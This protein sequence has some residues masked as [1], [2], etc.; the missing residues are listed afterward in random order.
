MSATPRTVER[1]IAKAEPLDVGQA[2]RAYRLARIFDLAVDLI[3]DR[4]KATRW[5]RTPHRYLGDKTPL[6]MLETE[7]GTESVEQSLHTIAYGG[8]G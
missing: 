2:D 3:G 5:L 8:V 6:A 7:I 1:R 4:S